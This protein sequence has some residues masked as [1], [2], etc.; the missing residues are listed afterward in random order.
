MTNK[1]HKI[2]EIEK[3]EDITELLDNYIDKDSLKKSAR[4]DYIISLLS[5][6]FCGCLT[7]LALRNFLSIEP[8]MANSNKAAVILFSLIELGLASYQGYNATKHAI[9][10]FSKNKRIAKIE[11]IENKDLNLES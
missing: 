6:I 7:G 2:K 11:S 5:G 3:S 8:D 10:H 9:N 1:K 4:L